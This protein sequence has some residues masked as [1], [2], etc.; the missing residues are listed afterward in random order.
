M[1]M[2]MRIQA[3][4]SRVYRFS[5]TVN[6]RKVRLGAAMCA[7]HHGLDNLCAII[8]YNKLR[9][10]RAT[11][12]SCVCEPLAAK[13]RAFDWPW[14]KIADT[15][16][17][18]SSRRS[19]AHHNARKAQRDHRAHLSGQGVPYMENVPAVHGSVK[20]TARPGRGSIAVSHASRN[21]IKELL[22]ANCG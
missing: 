22:D 21:E 19:A 17:R 9:A 3:K 16:F 8:D 4:P 6:S 10:T 20:L 12:R 5:A 1:A 15:I 11:T 18:R 2:G 7:A 14:S 13:W